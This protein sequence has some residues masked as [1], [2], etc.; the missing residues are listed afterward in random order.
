MSQSKIVLP[1]SVEFVMKFFSV[2]CCLIRDG[3][4]KFSLFAQ[5]ALGLN[6]S[7]HKIHLQKKFYFMLKWSR[8]IRLV[9]AACTRSQH[10]IPQD[11]PINFLSLNWS[12][13]ITKG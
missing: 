2:S 11:T 7:F 9:C 10:V 4:K 1:F 3:Q 6:V 5:L 12:R 13:L 8:L